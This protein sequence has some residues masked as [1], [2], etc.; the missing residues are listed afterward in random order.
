MLLSKLT[1]M[2]TPSHCCAVTLHSA[3]SS[4]TS[5]SSVNCT[6]MSGRGREECGCGG[7]GTLTTG[8]F[9]TVET[10]SIREENRQ[11]PSGRVTLSHTQMWSVCSNGWCTMTCRWPFMEATPH[12]NLTSTKE[13]K[14]SVLFR[15]RFSPLSFYIG[16]G[17]R[18]EH[19]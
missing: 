12:N 1:R 3:L 11:P 17:L 7:K 4:P 6:P 9:F 2:I 5:Y 8:E 13:R 10:C 16:H 15:P 14:L 19:F 18:E